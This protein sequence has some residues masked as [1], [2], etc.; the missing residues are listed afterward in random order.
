MIIYGQLEE[1]IYRYIEELNIN[2]ELLL[3]MGML[4]RQEDLL[5]FQKREERILHSLQLN[6]LP[7]EFKQLHWKSFEE[8]RYVGEIIE[9]YVTYAFFRYICR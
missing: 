2:I 7:I 9:D 8:N 4:D 3:K 5:P 6:C 1:G